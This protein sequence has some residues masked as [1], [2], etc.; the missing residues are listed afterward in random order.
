MTQSPG[1]CLGDQQ[2]IFIA[3][4]LGEVFSFSCEDT[5]ILFLGGYW[6]CVLLVAQ[7]VCEVSCSSGNEEAEFIVPLC[8]ES[9]TS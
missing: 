6:V 8:K 7:H 4:E 3:K 1:Q 9:T 5:S 2:G